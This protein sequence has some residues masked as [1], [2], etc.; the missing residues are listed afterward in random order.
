MCMF[1]LQMLDRLSK[2]HFFTEQFSSW[3]S[4]RLLCENLYKT[5]STV[6]FW[7]HVLVFR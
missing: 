6:I 2:E 7:L 3:M 1:Y 5:D 4:E